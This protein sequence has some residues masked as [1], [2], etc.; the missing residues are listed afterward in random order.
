MVQ[1]NKHLHD[2][3]PHFTPFLSPRPSIF[4]TTNDNSDYF[5]SRPSYS[6]Y[7]Q[8]SSTITSQEYKR[9]QEQERKPKIEIF[10]ENQFHRVNIIKRE[11]SL[12]DDVVYE[13]SMTSTGLYVN[14]H[15]NIHRQHT[16]RYQDRPTLDEQA[17]IHSRPSVIRNS[18]CARDQEQKFLQMEAQMLKMHGDLLKQTGN[19]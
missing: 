15:T 19:I 7:P 8:P 1:P 6:G 11:P 2:I 18:N 16:M 10:E 5:P 14:P 9:E 17:R 4:S 12:L 13:G 3:S